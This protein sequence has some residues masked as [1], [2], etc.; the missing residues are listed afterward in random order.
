MRHNTS[1]WVIGTW[2]VFL[3]LA[4]LAA[5]AGAQ[6]KPDRDTSSPTLQHQ[7]DTKEN[8]QERSAYGPIQRR[9]YK[10]KHEVSFGL[11][12]LPLDSYY[13][14]YGVQLAYTIHL[15]P[16]VA[17][18][19]FRIGWSYNVDTKLKKKLLTTIPDVH[20]EDFPAVVFFEN[21][22]LVLNVLYG[23]HSFLNR[24]V[25]HFELFVTGGAAFVFRNPFNVFELDEETK[26]Y[27]RFE[28]GLN[29]GVGFRVWIDPTWSVRVDL[30]DT[31]ML[32][33]VTNGD[34]P[35]KQSLMVGLMM[36]VNL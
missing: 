21:T 27:S 35:L 12:Y 2:A 16:V 36:S 19:L 10:M 23:K 8:Y 6:D 32:I 31:V 9:M 3:F 1:P 25:L 33:N 5:A 17:I 29:A 28:L 30:R 4:L 24:M 20:Q 7:E 22:N 13:K 34:L 18:E 26:G 14:G 15:S 11:A